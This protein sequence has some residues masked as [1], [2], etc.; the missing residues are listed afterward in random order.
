MLFCASSTDVMAN[1]FNVSLNTVLWTF[2]VIVFALPVITYFVTY[3]ICNEMRAAEGIG[4]RK[5]AMVVSRSETGEYSTVSTEP[6]PGDG[7]H[8]L[9]AIPVPTYINLTP[10]EL[11]TGPGVRRVMR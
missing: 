7:A 6:R 5:R 8:E 2:R 3:R 4:K 11:E 9:D 10:E 1:F